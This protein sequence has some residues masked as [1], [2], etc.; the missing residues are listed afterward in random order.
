MVFQ[1]NF[2]KQIRDNFVQSK[3]TCV[4]KRK[5]RVVGCA[6]CVVLVDSVG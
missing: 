3:F 5:E 4:E 6:C 1:R 2:W